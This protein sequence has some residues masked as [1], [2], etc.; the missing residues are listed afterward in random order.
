MADREGRDQLAAGQQVLDHDVV[1]Q[2]HAAAIHGL[3]DG[4]RRVVEDRAR[5]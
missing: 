1:G 5:V 4:K 2:R 3:T